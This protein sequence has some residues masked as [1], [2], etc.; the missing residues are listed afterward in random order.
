LL[1]DHFAVQHDIVHE[2]T[3]IVCRFRE[4]SIQVE[5]GGEESG[6]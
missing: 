5:I 6:W 2:Y 3:Q 1:F 4:L